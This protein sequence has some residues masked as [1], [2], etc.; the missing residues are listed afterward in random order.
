[1]GPVEISEAEW[2]TA[3][4]ELAEM[5]G[6]SWHHETDSR[7]TK[8]GW[9]DLVLWRERIVFVELKKESGRVSPAQAAVLDGL[10]AAG[11][12]VYVWRP[13]DL[14]AVQRVL[15]RRV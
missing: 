5:L 6:W 7:R 4:L 9:P 11:G 3:V 8:A 12:E 10:A 2:Q 15:S 13:S 1:M 14:P